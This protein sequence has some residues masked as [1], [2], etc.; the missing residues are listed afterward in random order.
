MQ[1][2]ELKG[3]ITHKEWDLQ[4]LPTT[5]KIT[6][7]NPFLNLP[8]LPSRSFNL[9]KPVKIKLLKDFLKKDQD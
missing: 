2:Q 5:E 3:F 7:T 4:I 9:N 6:E 1:D 8:S